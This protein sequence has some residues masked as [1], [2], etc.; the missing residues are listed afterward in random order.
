MKEITKFRNTIFIVLNFI[1]VMWSSGNGGASGAEMGGSYPLHITSKCQRKDVIQ[2]YLISCVLLRCLGWFLIYPCGLQ[3]FLLLLLT[4]TLLHHTLPVLPE[5]N[6]SETKQKIT[7]A[8][9]IENIF[10][11]VITLVLCI[12]LPRA[13][14][15]LGLAVNVKTIA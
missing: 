9:A 4:G 6:F 8:K 15:H 7:V 11:Y 14:R 2:N 12:L 10:K 13:L 3:S 5:R 1:K